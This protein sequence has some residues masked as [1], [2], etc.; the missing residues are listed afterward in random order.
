[1]PIPNA[2]I[3]TGTPAAVRA[4]R[5]KNEEMNNRFIFGGDA[6]LRHTPQFY[7]GIF[8]VSDI[9]H[10]IERPW[11]HPQ[12]LGPGYTAKF[13]VVPACEAGQ[14]YG[15]PFIIPDI[16]QMP[17]ENP[18]SWE[19]R[20]IGQDGRWLAQ[21]AINPEDPQ[22]N[23]R[24][25]RPVNAGMTMNEGTNLY[26][27]GCFWT[28]GK[29]IDELK[30]SDEEVE[31]AHNRLTATFEELANQAELL[32]LEGAKGLMQIGNLHRRAANYLSEHFGREF[33]WNKKFVRMVPCG[34]CGLPNNPMASVCVHAP[35]RG[36]MNWENAVKSGVRTIKDARNAGIV[37]A[38]DVAE[39]KN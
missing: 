33:N 6:N 30:P 15:R 3:A 9:E 34:A 21:D 38:W 11:V 23:W 12:A 7:V 16:V 5:L 32:S 4:T 29:S 25:V 27:L 39:D 8:N 13:I 35:C 26:R 22:G 37:L 18:G 24:T 31:T 10:K 17:I 19:L 1:M 36:V 28:I 20:T 14:P 2:T